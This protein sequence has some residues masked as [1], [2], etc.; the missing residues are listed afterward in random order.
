MRRLI[1]F[2]CD[3]LHEEMFVCHVI[4][5]ENLSLSIQSSKNTKISMFVILKKLYF[6]HKRS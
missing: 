6:N 5:F 1:W 4:H 2:I 3:L